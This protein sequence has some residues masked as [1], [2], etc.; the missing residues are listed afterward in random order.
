M[1]YL[2]L[3]VGP[4]PRGFGKRCCAL[5][6]TAAGAGDADVGVDRRAEGNL[7]ALTFIDTGNGRRMSVHRILL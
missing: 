5:A 7:F 4:Y 6:T 2:L 1:A 3:R